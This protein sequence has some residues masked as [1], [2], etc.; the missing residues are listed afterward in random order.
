MKRYN[1]ASG[2]AAR[3]K[4]HALIVALPLT[5][6]LCACGG[7][8]ADG[9]VNSTPP[10]VSSPAQ[11]VNFAAVQANTPTSASGITR[12]GSVTIE[13]TGA[14][15]QSGVAT[16][17]EGTGT[18]NFTLDGARQAT[19]LQINGSQSSVNF[20]ASNANS[21]QLVL[22]G[23]PVAALLS[24]S[25]GSE[26]A[27]FADPYVLGFNHQTFGVWGTGLV[28]GATG[29]YGAMSAGN[30]TNA[31]AVPTA[32]NVTYR[33]VAGGIYTDG[34]Q[35]RYAA[36]A[37]FVVNF[38]NRSIDFS[39]SNQTL[40]GILTNVTNRVGILSIRG[41]MTYSPGSVTFSGPLTANGQTSLRTM[42]GSGSGTFYGPSA[43]EIGG[44]FFLRGP[45]A[46][47]IGGFGGKQ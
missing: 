4:A 19:A 11:L 28:A 20:N 32:G 8:G 34:A 15:L 35:S 46:T 45:S 23:L 7:G 17:T 36:D 31:A 43:N 14:I 38:A 22:N 2:L 1:V 26:Q 12:E 47:L 25:S 27:I 24:N 16:P 6:T 42:S 30:R 37:T 3:Q 33:G 41:T 29:R 21:A 44:T 40:T 9:R 39:T 10:P 5:L 18:V 13:N